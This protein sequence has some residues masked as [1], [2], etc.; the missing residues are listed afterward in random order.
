MINYR[1][2]QR[3]ISPIL[4]LT[5]ICVPHTACQSKATPAEAMPD[6]PPL[7]DLMREHGMLNRLLLIDEE[8]IKRVNDP[9]FPI[10]QL[11]KAV[12]IVQEF[13]E[14]YHEKLEE[15][16]IF[17]LFER[18]GKEVKLC[19]TLRT[20][21]IQGREI[22]SRLKQI[23]NTNPH[24]NKKT[25]KTIVKLLKKFIRMYRPHEAREDTVIFP[26]VRSLIS[27]A[28]L[29]ELGETFEDIEHERF[30]ADG[31]EGVLEQVADIEKELGIYELAQFNPENQ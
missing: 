14:S 26:Q 21:H 24:P 19:A 28:D 23:C 25:R 13:I 9:V 8:I 3:L 22:T 11:K 20:Q 2:S 5:L 10:K 15:E 1:F 7:E 30:G 27:E 4:I 29:K 16:Y 12:N 17:P 18:A 6:V 31:F